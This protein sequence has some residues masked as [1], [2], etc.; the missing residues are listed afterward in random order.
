LDTSGEVC[1]VCGGPATLILL[2]LE[3]FV[4]MVRFVWP[5]RAAWVV[6]GESGPELVH[7]RCDVE[8]L[9]HVGERALTLSQAVAVMGEL[10]G[11]NRC[12]LLRKRLDRMGL[13]E[14]VAKQRAHIRRRL[15]EMWRP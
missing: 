14:W 12:G 15:D 4:R 1:A 2:P 11:L 8:S 10:I 9:E 6:E 7:I 3:D 5:E 13:E